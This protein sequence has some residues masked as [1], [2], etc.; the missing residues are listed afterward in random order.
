MNLADD[1]AGQKINSRAFAV[2]EKLLDGPPGADGR[3][4]ARHA[5][6]EKRETG[7]DAA[8]GDVKDAVVVNGRI[9]HD[10]VT[11]NLGDPAGVDLRNFRNSTGYDLHRAAAEIR[12]G[13]EAVSPVSGVEAGIADDTGIVR[14]CVAGDI[15][16]RCCST[17][18]E[19]GV[20]S[21]H[22][23]ADIKPR[24]VSHRCIV[25][26][27]GLCRGGRLGHLHPGAV[28]GNG[29]VVDFG[30]VVHPDPISVCYRCCFIHRDQRA[31]DFAGDIDRC[32]LSC[33]KP[34]VLQLL[35]END[36]A[37]ADDRAGL[38]RRDQ[39]PAAHMNLA[40]DGAGQKINPRAFAV[41]EKLLD[42]S[43]GADGRGTARYAVAEKRE[44]RHGAA[45]R[46]RNGS[47][48]NGGAAHQ[49]S[50]ILPVG[51]NRDRTVL[52]PGG[53]VHP[54]DQNIFHD[55]AGNPEFTL[56]RHLFSPADVNVKPQS[57]L[58]IDPK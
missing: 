14:N 55:R 20:V 50:G 13:D 6:A 56:P 18:L 4:T 39:R 1:G 32:A 46:H 2:G 25:G 58:C 11:E 47:A 24:S 40:D 12:F 34:S 7:G 8:A 3:G 38:K 36:L 17:P 42:G 53:A 29:T 43:P 23:L 44:T 16:P 51:E 21:L 19:R 49:H 57:I 37:A 5:V 33:T 10:P 27:G 54:R 48:G 52:R 28:N 45:R 30:C 9:R 35:A 15:K 26:F 22:I 41:G 31:A